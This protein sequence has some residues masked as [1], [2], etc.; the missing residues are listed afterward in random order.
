MLSILSSTYYKRFS[1]YYKFLLA[2]F[3]LAAL[4]LQSCNKP[5]EPPEPP[6]PPPPPVVKPTLIL[7][8]DD[9]HCTETWIL[10][11]TKDLQLPAEL[12]LKQ[13]KPNGDSI[14][15]NINVTTKDTL[16]YIDSLCPNQ[17]YR[18]QVSGI[19]YPKVDSQ[20]VVTSNEITV[21]TMDTTS[22][23]FTFEMV[24]FGGEIG[25]SVLFDVAIINENN[26]WA[27]GDIWI[28]SDT[29]S[30]GYIKYNAVHWNGIEWKLYRIMFYTVCGQSNL[31]PY[32]ARSVSAFNENDV[33]ISMD[34]DQIA[35]IDGENQISIQCLPVSFSIFKLWGSSSNNLYAV[36]WG[37]NIVHYNGT[38]WKKLASGTT[39][40]INDIWGDYNP[41]TNEW[42]ILAVA[43]NKF[44]NEG[45]DVLKIIGQNSTILNKDGLPWSISSV[46]F[47]AGKKYFI[48]GDGLFFNKK[49]NENWNKDTLFIP[50]YKDRIRG[51]NINDIVVS[52]SNGL[53]S[54]FNGYRWKHYI[55]NELPYYSGRLLSVDLKDNT[56]VAVGWI[57]SQAIITIG[58]R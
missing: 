6:Q 16:L 36:G 31:I 51:I 58:R 56:T 26:I 3:L 21:L 47:K 57:G 40:N 12:L 33:W 13:Y 48:G 41:K 2:V 29:T 54:H 52:G 43:S 27:V 55:N 10:L 39:L 53:L 22:S 50:I 45:L 17:T 19:W 28:K 4:F 23:S 32:P 34:G 14:T 42:E 18:Y 9:A 35:R 24:T 44:F 7:E 15:Q 8:L 49:I 30:T 25:S 1:P 11:S 46:W 20:Q 37:G 5:T 38:N